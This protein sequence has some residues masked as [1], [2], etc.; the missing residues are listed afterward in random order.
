MKGK[1]SDQTIETVTKQMIDE[2]LD[3]FGNAKAAAEHLGIP[4]STFYR[5]LKTL[6][7][8]NSFVDKT[9]GRIKWIGCL[10]LPVHVAFLQSLNTQVGIFMDLFLILGK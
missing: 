1:G 8:N 6:G 9:V 10:S 2:A 3:R 7:E 5:R 4:K